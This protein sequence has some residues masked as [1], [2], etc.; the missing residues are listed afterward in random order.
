MADSSD[1]TIRDLL[2]GFTTMQYQL[3]LMPGA[4]SHPPMGVALNGPPPM[5]PTMHP[6]EAALQAVQTHQGLMQQTIQAAQL[7][8]YMPPPSA[9]T[10]SMGG[11]MGGMGGGGGGGGFDMGWGS[12]LGAAQAGQA[13]PY[14]AQMM[15]GMPGMPGAGMMTAPQYGVFRSPSMMGAPPPSPMYGMGVPQPSM[16]F[17]PQM[18]GAHFMTP[19]MQNYRVMQARQSHAMAGLSMMFGG[20]GSFLGGLGGGLAGGALGT[21]VAG[22]LGGL[23]GGF[24]GEMAGA[25]L[26]GLPHQMMAQPVMQDIQRGRQIQGM[27]SPWMVSGQSLDPFTGQGMSR[28]AGQ[29]T[30][31]LI[32]EMA[33]DH[34]FREKVAFNT[35][36]VM[37]ITQLASDQGMLQ[38]VQNPQQ[39]AQQVKHIAQAVKFITQVSGDPDVRNAVASL[40]QMRTL[41]FEGLQAQTG[42]LYN[43]AQFSRMAG[44]SQQQMAQYEA[45]GAMQ[46]TQMGLSGATGVRAAQ[47]GAGL[48]NVA[49]NTGAV[50]GL[51]LARTGGQQGLTQTLGQAQMA[52]AAFDPYLMAA[53]EQGAGGR[54][55]INMEAYRANQSRSLSDVVRMGGER[56]HGLGARGML[57]FRRQRAE[58]G[59]R[60]LQDMSPTEQMMM[61]LRQAQA[62]QKD[63]GGDLD[64]G[65]AFEMLGQRTGMT[66][67]QLQAMQ[68]TY[69]DPRTYR[70]L[71][72]QLRSQMREAS[73]RERAR[74]EQTRTPGLLRGWGRGINDE[75][76]GMSD[77]LIQPFGRLAESLQQTQ[78]NIAA[79]NNNEA[80]LRTPS[81]AV[82]TT[83]AQRQLGAESFASGAS[84]VTGAQGGGAGF[85]SWGQ[86]IGGAMGGYFAGSMVPMPGMAAA[87]AV[88]GGYIGALTGTERGRNRLMNTFN[89]SA[90]TTENKL[91][92]AADEARGRTGFWDRLIGPTAGGAAMSGA[93]QRDYGAIAQAATSAGRMKSDQF[94][95]LARTLAKGSGID[96]KAVVG[97]AAS[98]L[99][100]KIAAQGGE[101]AAL[102]SADFR[103]AAINQLS[104]HM[105]KSEAEKAYDANPEKYN[106][107]ISW[108]IQNG[109]TPHAKEALNKASTAQ[110]AAMSAL[111]SGQAEATSAKSASDMKTVLAGAGVQATTKTSGWGMVLGGVTA[112]ALAPAMGLIGIAG[113]AGIGGWLGSTKEV[114]SEGIANL[115]KEL[116]DPKAL[117][118]AAALQAG[119]HTKL[120]EIAKQMGIDPMSKDGKFEALK[121]SIGK[122]IGTMK[123][124]DQD[125]L[126]TMG[127]KQGASELVK[128]GEEVV[129]QVGQ[130]MANAALIKF[131][132]KVSGE[133]PGLSEGIAKAGDLTSL[134]STLVGA[135]E[136]QLAGVSP[137]LKGYI[138]KYKGAKTDA[139]KKKIL[140]QIGQDNL[141]AAGTEIV[142]GAQG[143]ESGQ[144]RQDIET[145]RAARGQMANTPE[146]QQAAAM[147]DSA[148][149]FGE[150]AL[151]FKDAINGLTAYL[152][153]HYPHT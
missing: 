54:L 93:Q 73:G 80:I 82:A 17:M 3:G 97:N 142:G 121:A 39:L 113:A 27:T 133:M 46:A 34:E 31:R 94:T 72:Q 88:A 56:M 123:P 29:D 132:D 59:E 89:M 21:A 49:V 117:A 41:G 44:V 24:A 130:G 7:T 58:L 6:S 126:K 153:E 67:G 90:L 37:R 43:R 136:D 40:G 120:H 71:E 19:V 128:T 55:Q 69:S 118:F 38:V 104:A 20:G 110:E 74:R 131:K 26:G 70:A 30:A 98:N 57:A 148:A 141:P 28:Q 138:D 8:R 149:L 139:D 146:G 127:A 68:Q 105:S 65:S 144:M 99:D 42:A 61:P 66:P 150:G 112:A 50:Q 135:S 1:D 92:L 76:A 45:A 115:A 52:S 78:E 47:F 10:P 103:G 84:V 116:R 79:Q 18:P 5:P 95:D 15:G 83:R 51:A 124:G 14:L 114:A 32:R 107:A 4:Q 106:T 13:N 9:P 22:P 134:M 140:E 25:A 129:K 53:V 125:A 81:W 12:S 77:Q 64:L 36:D 11:S 122:K 145:L 75:L 109:A 23:A 33:R 96:I 100:T 108:A 63:V 143:T 91:A 35:Q 147:A 16:P 87:G 119:D 102:T 151:T 137:T 2:R 86:N 152:A 101:P 62:I 48:A 60:A 111:I 85:S